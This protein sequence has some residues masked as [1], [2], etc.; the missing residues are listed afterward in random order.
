MTYLKEPQPANAASVSRRSLSGIHHVTAIAR[1]PEANVRFYTQV[2]GMRLVKLT[3]NQDAPTVYHLYYGD[4]LGQPGTALT[5]FPWPR[6]QRGQPG[7]GRA[8]AVSFAVPPDSWA[9]WTRWLDQ[10]GVR[11]AG[12]RARFD[13]EVVA[14]QDPDG[15][16]LELVAHP[17][18]D[19]RRAWEDGP[20]PSAHAVRG[21][22]GV[23]LWERALEA[24][25]QFMT[26]TL[27]FER[28]RRDDETHR[29]RLG[30]GGPG[31]LVDVRELPAAKAGAVS[32]G[33]IHHV[34]WRVSD[35]VQLRAWRECVG[36]GGLSVTP[37]IDRHYFRSLYFRE[38]GGALFELA[39]DPPG[40]A[41][42]EPVDALGSNLVLPPW[43]E[44]K[45][46]RIERLLPAPP[47]K[48][49]EIAAGKGR[50]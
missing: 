16:A 38:P 29:Y 12:P 19:D 18:A 3:V 32:V 1:D 37:V 14:L 44:D 6:A 24:T 4:A 48:L 11:F 7:A 10:H 23:T 34:A 43:L 42:D 40:F 47:A 45:R 15:L 22:Y 30:A 31:A 21:L 8:V 20:I 35:D 28:D 17:E 39:T 2:L 27:G 26:G 49:I 41:I 46:E 25:D 33:S 9:F 36:A 13:E 50:P 5:F